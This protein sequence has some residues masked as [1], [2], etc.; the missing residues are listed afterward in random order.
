M[1]LQ[2]VRHFVAKSRQLVSSAAFSCF[3]LRH[4]MTQARILWRVAR[5]SAGGGAEASGKSGSLC[6]ETAGGAPK[7]IEG[8]A[9]GCGGS[10]VVGC[11][12]GGSGG[13]ESGWRFSSACRA[14]GEGFWGAAMANML[15]A[16]VKL[17]RANAARNL[18]RRLIGEAAR[19]GL[20]S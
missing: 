9:G 13:R 1:F 6:R 4:S 12:A 15:L 16:S 18:P 10:G 2:R 19:S 11:G 14:P 17:V 7:E 20:C 5:G 3:I 8:A